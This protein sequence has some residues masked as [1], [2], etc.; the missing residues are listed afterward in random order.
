MAVGEPELH[1]HRYDREQRNLIAPKAVRCHSVAA[2]LHERNQRA[3]LTKRKHVHDDPE[4]QHDIVTGAR[5]RDDVF[6]A[7]EAEHS[8]GAHAIDTPGVESR[9]RGAAATV[10]V[11]HAVN[12]DDG[13]ICLAG[14][15]RTRR[16]RRLLGARG[17]VASFW[18]SR[19]PPSTSPLRLPA[20]SHAMSA[21][22]RCTAASVIVILAHV[23]PTRA[24]GYAA[25]R[26]RSADWCSFTKR[27]CFFL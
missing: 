10:V 3:H 2:S 27:A 11:A 12:V 21:V 5:P 16:P 13:R 19:L 15:L 17:G 8:E 23:A 26:N 7:S 22:A 18:S 4:L 6:A 24:W 14:A 20:R 1:E 9:G 25:E